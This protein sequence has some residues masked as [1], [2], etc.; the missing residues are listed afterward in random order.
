[1]IHEQF[2]N[3]MVVVNIFCCGKNDEYLRRP[4]FG[5]FNSTIKSNKL[6]SIDD[7]KFPESCYK[8]QISSICFL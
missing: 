3:L 8:I 7:Y 1:M 2:H 6:E 4:S 5:E